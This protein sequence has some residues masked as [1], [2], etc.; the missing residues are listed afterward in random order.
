MAA[1][2]AASSIS[3]SF[4]RKTHK[5]ADLRIYT[6]RI[7][8]SSHPEFHFPPLDDSAQRVSFSILANKS[9]A[10]AGWQRWQRGG[11]LHIKR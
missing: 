10:L 11:K 1:E 9:N 7:E 8:S 2:A 3:I 4:V 5:E 6:D